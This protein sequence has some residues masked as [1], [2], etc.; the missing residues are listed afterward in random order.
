MKKRPAEKRTK[1]A[2]KRAATP[3]PA[4]LHAAIV[5]GV[6]QLQTAGWTVK[7]IAAEAGVPQSTLQNFISG[8]RP[9]IKLATADKL[10][11]WLKIGFTAAKRKW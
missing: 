2:A 7:D 10:A 5:A 3:K 1:K 8:A 6:Q 9:D 4:S 11:A